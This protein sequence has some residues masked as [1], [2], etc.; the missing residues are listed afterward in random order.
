MKCFLL[1]VYKFFCVFN[2]LELPYLIDAEIEIIN[3]NNLFI[4][5]T[6]TPEIPNFKEAMV[7]NQISHLYINKYIFLYIGYFIDV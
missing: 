3:K 1:Q 4:C 6:D 7:H 5:S 2:V